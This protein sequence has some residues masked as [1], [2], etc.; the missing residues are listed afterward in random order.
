MAQQSGIPKTSAGHGRVSYTERP[1]LD[2]I[3]WKMCTTDLFGSNANRREAHNILSM[4]FVPPARGGLYP[5]GDRQR[6]HC[7]HS[8]TTP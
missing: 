2:A 5:G 8:F 4:V 7:R 1:A 6:S 3:G